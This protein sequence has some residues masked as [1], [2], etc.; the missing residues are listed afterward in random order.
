MEADIA[1][2]DDPV[3]EYEDEFGR[4]R[5]ARRSEV[6]RHLL[7]RDDDGDGEDPTIEYEDEFGRIRT[8]RRSEV[9]RHLWPRE[10][11]PDA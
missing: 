1:D 5:S 4:L 10:A 8:A 11:D 2:Q 9:P 3:V 7:S 6:P